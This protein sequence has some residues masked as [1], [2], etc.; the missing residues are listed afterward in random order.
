MTLST[1]LRMLS[2]A[3]FAAALFVAA[4]CDELESDS[5]DALKI[6]KHDHD[7]HDHDHDDHDHDHHD[8]DHDGH[9][10]DH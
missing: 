9:D 6:E 7:H 4:G 2:A 10:H 1:S 5:R 3:C 8:H